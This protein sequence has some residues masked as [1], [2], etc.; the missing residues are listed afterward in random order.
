MIECR[1]ADL[2]AHGLI[3]VCAA[4]DGSLCDLLAQSQLPG[5]LGDDLGVEAIESLALLQGLP[6]TRQ[7][8]KLQ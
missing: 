6:D 4:F 5:T 3:D 1:H 8:M 2:H 7:G